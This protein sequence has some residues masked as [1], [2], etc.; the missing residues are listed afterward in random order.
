MKENEFDIY[1][2]NLMAEAEEPVS[3]RVWK[4]VNAALDAPK[5]VVPIWV[6]RSVASVAAAAAVVA[7]VVLIRPKTDNSQPVT[8]LNPVAENLTATPVEESVAPED[9]Y[10]PLLQQIARMPE[11]TAYVPEVQAV[12]E[13]M[14][15]GTPS[16]SQS[17]VIGIAP[18]E[19]ASRAETDEDFSADGQ[20][21]DL[22]AATRQGNRFK[23]SFSLTAG[24]NMQGNNR[25]EIQPSTMRRSA[26]MLFI[27]ARPTD[28]ISNESPE[29]HFSLPFTVGAGVRFR[30]APRWSAGTGIQ[31]TNMSRTFVA[32]YGDS[33][34]G[35][36]LYGT[37][38]DNHQHWLGVPLNVYFDIIRTG[39]WS[40]N[41]FVGGTAEYLVKNQFL[42]QHAGNDI[43]YTPKAHGLQYSTGVGV[44]VQFDISPRVSLYFDPS[45]RYYYDTGQPRSIRTIQPLRFDMQGGV[46]FNFGQ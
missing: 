38:I 11:R 31:Y 34:S 26:A 14:E 43:H 44:G 1:I 6:W 29:T 40:V 2:R 21:L 39:R 9:E 15:E 41:T 36:A 37:S 7:G 19:T 28:G 20:L 4:G 18:Q 35:I 3:P 33:E 8:I 10:V 16:L 30:F 12:P 22:L 32:D 46:R 25:P 5:R 45:L 42:V 24:G 13:T 27:P 23:P 17:S